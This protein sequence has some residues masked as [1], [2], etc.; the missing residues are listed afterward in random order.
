MPKILIAAGVILA[1]TLIWWFAAGSTFVALVDH[2]TTAPTD[3]VTPPSFAFDEGNAATF[4]SPKFTVGDRTRAASAWHVVE[5]PTGY[6]SLETAGGSFVFG[7]LTRRE[8]RGGERHR[9]EFSADSSDV[10]SLTRRESRLSWPRPFVINWLGGP[11]AAWARHVYYRLVWRK[12]SGDTLDVLWRDEK[13][14]EKGNG[15]IDQYRSTEPAT[16]LTTRAR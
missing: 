12:A 1:G 4:E 14:F 8:S 16:R 13:R 10:V 6:V 9:Y 2:L 3:S 5:R 7:T 15:W 11:R